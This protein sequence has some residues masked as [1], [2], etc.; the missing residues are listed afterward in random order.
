MAGD[1]ITA[2]RAGRGYLL[3]IVSGFFSKLIQAGH[4]GL[5]V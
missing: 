3:S 5:S 4:L 1:Q 2:I